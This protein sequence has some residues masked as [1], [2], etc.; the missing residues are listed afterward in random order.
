MRGWN[1]GG[2]I[3]EFIRDDDA[4]GKLLDHAVEWFS[5][6]RELATFALMHGGI[7]VQPGD[8]F[9]MDH[10]KLKTQHRALQMTALRNGCTNSATVLDLTL[11]EAGLMRA[12]DY[13]YLQDTASSA[14]E[15][16]LID[17]VDTINDQVTVQRAKLNTVAS[18]YVAS[19]GIMRLTWKWLVTGVRPPLP[20]D[21]RILI[22]AERMPNSYF[23]VGIAR[24]SSPDWDAA[25]PAQRAQVG[26]ATLQNGKVVDNDADSNISYARAA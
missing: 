12:G 14:P 15:A 20:T 13:F 2:Y 9:H 26:W 18:A 3:S 8:V 17:S 24:A 21:T 22:E 1:D 10:P 25:T 19:V 11:N 16:C 5:Q 23:P 4:A 7:L 6:P